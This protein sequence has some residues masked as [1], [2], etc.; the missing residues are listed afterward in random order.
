MEPATATLQEPKKRRRKLPNFLRAQEQT[1]LLEFCRAQIVAN[2]CPSKRDAALRD[3]VIVH[4]GLFCGLR[5]AEICALNVEH[6]DLAGATL[7]VCEGKGDKDRYVPIPARILPLLKNWVGARTSGAFLAATHN[8]RL[9]P[10][11]V[12]HRMERLGRLCGLTKKL[13]PHTLRHTAAVRLLEKGVDIETIREFLGH[14]N[15]AT[16][17][18]YLHCTAERLRAAVDLL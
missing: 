11:T 7:F 16:T 1:L 18:H 10:V 14:A 2:L 6:V 3:E 5:V 17:A 4:L 13:K 9:S 15:L 8:E 12:R